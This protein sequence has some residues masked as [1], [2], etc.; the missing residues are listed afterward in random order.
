M[1]IAHFQRGAR[2]A[3]FT[4][5]C[6]GVP[7]PPP[8]PPSVGQ[9][10][11]RSTPFSRKLEYFG[12][13]FLPDQSGGGGGTPQ[14]CDVKFTKRAI[15]CWFLVSLLI[16][17]KFWVEMRRITISCKWHCH[18]NIK[19]QPLYMLFWHP[20]DIYKFFIPEIDHLTLDWKSPAMLGQFTDFY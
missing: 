4:S 2:F 10:G 7:P 1:E 5:L 13:I 15:L 18:K 11:R 8:L 17:K 3:D 20:L 9:P 19:T 16:S 12:V 14:Q 6:C